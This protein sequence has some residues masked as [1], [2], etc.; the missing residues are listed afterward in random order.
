[1]VKKK[2]KDR[3]ERMIRRRGNG[4]ENGKEERKEAV[5]MKPIVLELTTKLE[6]FQRFSKI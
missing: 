3:R 2:R 1:M 4:R 6:I 5:A